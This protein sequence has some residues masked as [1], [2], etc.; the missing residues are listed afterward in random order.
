MAS[1]KSKTVRPVTPPFSPIP[2]PKCR[3]T[4]MEVGPTVSLV[5]SKTKSDEPG[6]L[7]TG[8][9]RLIRCFHGRCCN[10]GYEAEAIRQEIPIRY[11]NEKCPKC[12]ESSQFT[13]EVEELQLEG[14]SYRF[15]AIVRCLHCKR[16]S[17]FSKALRKLWS[18]AK[19]K[20]SAFGVEVE[21]SGNSG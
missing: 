1:T 19:L 16:Q 8:N 14:E 12:G 6:W 11:V 18:I 7:T 2:C 3:S 9:V 15:S 20:V 10:C 5:S 21:V 17:R 13:C 4:A